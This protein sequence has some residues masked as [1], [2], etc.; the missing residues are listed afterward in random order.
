MP[1]T[2]PVYEPRC[3]IQGDGHPLQW[4]NCTCASG[5]THL[6]RD[7]EGAHRTNAGHVRDLTRSP[8]GTPDRTGGNTLDQVDDA[9]R[10]SDGYDHMD[11]RRREAFEDAVYEVVGGRGAEIQGSYDGGFAGS[12]YDGSPGFTGNHAWYWNAVRLAYFSNGRIDYDSSLAQLWDPL[13]D[14]RRRGIPGYNS[15]APLK[16]VLRFRWIKL[17][18]LRRLA[19]MLRMNSGARL[20]VGYCYIGYT[21]ITMPPDTVPAPQPSPIKF[22][23]NQM[24][25]AGGLVL[26]SSHVVSVK[27][28]QPFY[29]EPKVGSEVVARASADY[30]ASAGRGLDYFG[31]GAPGW[32]SVLIVTGNFPDKVKRPVIVFCPRTAGS[33]TKKVV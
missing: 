33:V 20:G 15:A 27:K 14:G 10:Q 18:L 5:A 26:Q 23:A 22:G 12:I 31:Y 3:V 1:I 9:L 2:V 8:D 16:P 6:D 7:T 28:A 19:G 11:S 21:R 17:S 29:R 32:Y 4:L 13:W 30:L 24:I 25:V